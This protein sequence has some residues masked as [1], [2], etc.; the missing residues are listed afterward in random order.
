THAHQH[1]DTVT[2]PLR[3]KVPAR[4]SGMFFIALDGFEDAFRTCAVA[5][6]EP[7][8]AKTAT[9]FEESPG[10]RSRRKSAEQR[11]IRIRVNVIA[12]VLSSVG[13]VFRRDIGEAIRRPGMFLDPCLHRFGCLR[14]VRQC[15][16]NW[17]LSYSRLPGFNELHAL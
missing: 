9:D 1:S 13:F 14:F 4:D 10:F 8:V 15:R 16:H 3:P 2:D 6:P 17:L 5:E 7:A 11:T 12:P